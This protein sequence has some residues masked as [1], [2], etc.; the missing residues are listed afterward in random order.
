LEK[1]LVY[2][3]NKNRN[4]AD[5]ESVESVEEQN[6]VADPSSVK[7]GSTYLMVYFIRWVF[8]I[9]VLVAAVLLRGFVSHS[10]SSVIGGVVGK[11]GRKEEH[12]KKVVDAL[13]GPISFTCIVAGVYLAVHFA[14][15]PDDLE[16]IFDNIIKSLLDI[17]VFWIVFDLI[18]PISVIIQKT[19]TGQLKEEVRKVLVDLSKGLIVIL[20]FLSIL[21]FWGINVAAFLAGFGLVGMAVALAA[22]DTMK[23]FFASVAMFADKSFQ[24][25]RLDINTKCRRNC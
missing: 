1:L 12:K 6:F 5:V 16:P 22:Q 10:I 25:K 15:I 2:K 23:N 7:G 24:K 11:V 18:E 14:D 20:G 19:G 13:S 8:A 21:Q 9:G 3:Q 4:M 17:L